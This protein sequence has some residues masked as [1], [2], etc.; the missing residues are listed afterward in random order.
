MTFG[1]CGA[2]AG[3][4]V[5]TL[6]YGHAGDHVAGVPGGLWR[7]GDAVLARWR[8]GKDTDNNLGVDTDGAPLPYSGADVAATVD[9]ITRQGTPLALIARGEDGEI[10]VQVFGPPSAELAE[11]LEAAARGYRQAL[12]RGAGDE[13]GPKGRPA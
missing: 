11:A 5:C 6:A 2:R 10:G 1:L 4:F 9:R 7:I 8:P 13:P 3:R 12:E